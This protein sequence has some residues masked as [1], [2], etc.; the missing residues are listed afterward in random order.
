[1]WVLLRLVLSCSSAN[2]TRDNRQL[3]LPRRPASSSSTSSS[4]T[5]ASTT[6]LTV[7]GDEPVRPHWPWWR[8]TSNLFANFTDSAGTA[9]TIP[10]ARSTKYRVPDYERPVAKAV[11]LHLWM[12]EPSANRNSR[13]RQPRLQAAH[14]APR[15]RRTKPPR[16][17]RLGR[18]GLRGL[19]IWRHTFQPNRV[20]NSTLSPPGGQLGRRG[21]RQPLHQ[22]MVHC[23]SREG[24]HAMPTTSKQASPAPPKNGRRPPHGSTRRHG[25]AASPS[26]LNSAGLRP[27]PVI[28]REVPTPPQKRAAGSLLP[29]AAGDDDGIGAVSF[30]VDEL[31]PEIGHDP[32]CC[33]MLHVLRRSI[34]Q[35]PLAHF[36]ASRPPLFG[37]FGPTREG[38]DGAGSFS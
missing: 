27:K 5:R 36:S 17:S 33:A 16:P 11:P 20:G 34:Q 35:E 29:V 22:S 3:C 32:S 4:A 8:P 13:S 15:P 10:P 1:M 9:F 18:Q 28:R 12:D 2:H 7:R 26:A 6:Y 14:P 38:A 21:R 24:R 23:P 37:V 19:R 30:I 31:S 25:G